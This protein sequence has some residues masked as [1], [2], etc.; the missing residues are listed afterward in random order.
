M[1]IHR[2]DASRNVRLEAFFVVTSERV[3]RLQYVVPAGSLSIP[4]D[5][6]GAV[7]VGATF[8]GD[9]SGESFS[10]QGP[11]LDGRVK[12]DISAPDGV[13]TASYLA[14]GQPFFGT[15]A[16]TPHVAGAIALLKSR[17]GIY[18]LGQVVDILY[19]RAMDRGPT[20]RDNQFGAGRLDVV[21]R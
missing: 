8:W 14:I 13:D 2:Y 20:G 1:A 10:S 16:S 11:T 17:F 21:G 6:R 3:N 9:D 12:P 5:T 4:A 7:A 15:S 18:S 19:G